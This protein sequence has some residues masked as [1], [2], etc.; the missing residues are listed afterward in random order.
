MKR[1]LLILALL[2]SAGTQQASAFGFDWGLTG[3]ASMTKLK[4]KDARSKYTTENWAGWFIG[5]KINLSLIA[6]LGLDGSVVYNQ[7]RIEYLNKNLNSSGET[8]RS[9][10][11]PLNVRYNMGLGRV[12]SVYL[13]TGPQFGFS[14]SGH[15]WKG[16][17][18]FTSDNL[19]TT[20][21]VGVGVKLLSRLEVGLGYNFGIGK[22]GD[23]ESAQR[24]DMK[25]NAFQV[26]A[27]IYF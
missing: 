13:A 24:G 15:D 23:W 3:G 20:W 12:A 18:G 17:D 5:G 19:Y 9:I 25:K 6:G 7:Q 4:V 22:L 8:W 16:L 1:I 10:E 27:A 21:N 2:V 26:K 11:I 14:L